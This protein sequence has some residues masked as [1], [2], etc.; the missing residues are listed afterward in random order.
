MNAVT[1]GGSPLQAPEST[2][3]G[4][5]RELIHGRCNYTPKRL[6][7]PGPSPTELEE[8]L[9]AAGAAPDHGV[10]VPWRFV[11]IPEESRHA[12]GQVFQAALLDRDPSASPEQQDDAHDKALRAP[13]LL[14]AIVD[15]SPREKAVPD[16]ERLISL[17]CAIQNMLLLARALGYASGL[18]S[19]K[20][21]GSEALR[22]AFALSALEQATCFVSFGTAA[23]RKPRSR[24][25]SERLLSTFR[26]T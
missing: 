22:R 18:S 13:C 11:L 26:A 25:T 20:A 8:L 16:A 9:D 6:A 15:L 5:T 1:G 2:V 14:L 17:G 24:P 21:L 12:L 7:V 10:L 19:G 3:Q 23:E 4:W